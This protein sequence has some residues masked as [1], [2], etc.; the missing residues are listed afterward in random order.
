MNTFYVMLLDIAL[1]IQHKIVDDSFDVTTVISTLNTAQLHM[2]TTSIL[3]P[4]HY[5]N[6][7][8]QPVFYI[9]SVL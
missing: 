6:T 3:R 7:N 1:F 2:E 4:C 8:F 9:K 5:T